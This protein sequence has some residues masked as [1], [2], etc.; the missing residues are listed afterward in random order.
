[1][2]NTAKRKTTAHEVD[3]PEDI[4]WSKAKVVGRGTKTGRRF[5]LRT[6]RVAIGKTQE[7]IARA[8]EMAQSEVSRVETRDDIKVSTLERYVVAL[9]GKLEIS[10]TV[11]GRR[12]LVSV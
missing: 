2:A 4:D 6:L 1:M 12:Y 3:G 8:S 11:D 7:D 9:G 5:T 10:V